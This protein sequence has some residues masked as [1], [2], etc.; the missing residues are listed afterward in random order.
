MRLE[1]M[2]KIADHLLCERFVISE[3]DES[4]DK[5]LLRDIL[6]YIENDSG[7]YRQRVLPI[8]NNLARKKLSGKYDKEL[9]VKAFMYL[10]IDGI[11]KYKSEYEVDVTLSKAEKES[12]AKDLLDSYTEEIDGV[13]EE[14]KTKKK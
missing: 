11:K 8:V 2:T 7:L 4:L 14:L 5:D 13:V 3:K 12:L 9:A 6:V 10:A 1:D